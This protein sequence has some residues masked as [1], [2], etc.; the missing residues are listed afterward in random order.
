AMRLSAIMQTDVIYVLTHDSIG[1]GEDG[2][3]HQPIEH[4]AAL[5]ATPELRVVRPCDANETADAWLLALT[6]TGPTALVLTRQ[7]LAQFT[8][9]RGQ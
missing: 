8:E 2:A 7:N 6:T 9:T 3:T 5:R 1:V 4:L